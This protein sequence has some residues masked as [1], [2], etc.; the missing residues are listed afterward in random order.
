MN[1][2]KITQA[3][4]GNGYFEV[5]ENTEEKVVYKARQT[6]L[7]FFGEE[8]QVKNVSPEDMTRFFKTKTESIA[9][10]RVW[11]L[12]WDDEGDDLFKVTIENK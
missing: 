4:F 5:I 7:N 11:K 1:W 3:K 2:E 6:W 12:G 9:M 8:E 10:A